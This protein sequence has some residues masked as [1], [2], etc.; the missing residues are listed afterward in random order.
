MYAAVIKKENWNS[1]LINVNNTSFKVK[2]KMKSLFEM[3]IIVTLNNIL[4]VKIDFDLISY[5]W[6]ITEGMSIKI[7]KKNMVSA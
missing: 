3:L 4:I 7:K 1:I 6:F 2:K 5:K